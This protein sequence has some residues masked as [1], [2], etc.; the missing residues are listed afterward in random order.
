[1]TDEFRDVQRV[2]TQLPVVLR[3]KVVTSASRKAA[4]EIADEAK[5]RVPVDTGLLQKSI[6]VAKAKKK[7]TPEG[8]TRFYT[9]P[10]TKVNFSKVVRVNGQKGKLKARLSSFH[11]HFIEFG[12]KNISA[13]PFLLPAAKAVQPTLVRNF[14]KNIHDGVEKEV[15]KLAR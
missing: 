3:K 6:G 14:Q 1:M 4:K 12:T 2:L 10:K 8:I 13:K 15:R 11:S 5:K 9:V 7:D